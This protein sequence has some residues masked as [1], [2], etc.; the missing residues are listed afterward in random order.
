MK[1]GFYSQLALGSPFSWG[2]PQE[3]PAGARGRGRRALA[4]SGVC[5]HPA[6]SGPD[7]W[8]P[9]LAPPHAYGGCLLPS[10]VFVTSL[11]IQVDGR[12]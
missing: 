6:S 9:V 1:P 8:P 11:R 12:V 4:C 3:D 2:S 5:L 7:S 10:L